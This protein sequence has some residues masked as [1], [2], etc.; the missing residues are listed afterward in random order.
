MQSNSP[1]GVSEQNRSVT[2]ARI[3]IL[4]AFAICLIAVM[5]LFAGYEVVE[6]TW[7]GA[8]EPAVLHTLHILRGLAAAAI[9]ATLATLVVLSQL[10]SETPDDIPESPRTWKNRLQRVPLRTKVIVPMV[11]LSAIPTF[12]IGGFTISRMEDSLR[13]RVVQRIEFDTYSKALSIQAFLQGLHRD[14]RFLSKMPEIQDLAAAE[15]AG[16]RERL[17]RFRREAER[18]LAIFSQGRRGYQQLRYLNSSAREVLRLDVASGTTPRLV[19]AKKLSDDA[20]AFY[21]NSAFSLKPGKI[22]VSQLEL[23]EPLGAS[24][25]RRKVL[26]CATPVTWDDGNGR[27]LLV[28]NV[29]AMYFF[30]LVGTLPRLAEAWLLNSEGMYLGYVGES[31]QKQAMYSMTMKRP[32]TADFDADMSDAILDTSGTRTLVH[33]NS[34]LSAAPI[35][36]DA[37]ATEQRWTLMISQPLA[38]VYTPVRQTTILLWTAVALVVAIAATTG[39]FVAHYVA[40]PIA[41]LRGAT[42]EIADGNLSKRVTV[43]TGDEIEGLATD[44]N[45][46]TDRLH[47]A[48]T[49]L[50]GWNDELQREVAK[51]TD[52]LRRL[53]SG[54]A[55]ADKLAS[56]GQMTA[57]IMHEIGNPLA[58]IKTKIQ[59]AQEAGENAPI[60]Q[61]LLP[62][63]IHEVNRLTLVLRSFARL[64]R[65]REPTLGLIS[66]DEVVTEVVTLV[67]AEL[68]RKR[69][70]MVIES[71]ND[72]PQI[73]ADADQLRQL[74]INFILNASDA[75]EEGGEIAVRVGIMPQDQA[76]DEIPHGASIQVVDH[77]TGIP[78][79]LLGKIWD[80]FFTTKPQGTGLGLPISRKIVEDHGGAV[81]I[82]SGPDGTV[83]TMIFPAATERYLRNGASNA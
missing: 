61:D 31:K 47:E 55:R 77:G 50:S 74:L 42:R 26:R 59:V 52:D 45:T 68:R 58:A 37:E 75:T 35:A 29:D 27:G 12:A 2:A 76:T 39:M 18:E 13:E 43:H 21:L 70:S 3:S 9:A 25:S 64:G 56:I 51:R 73:R 53:Q 38:P 11:L 32:I 69:I 65:L 6:R 34:L 16:D 17:P 10:E 40:R 72:A 22:Y 23:D 71:T 48:R 36:F 8:V 60:P 19:A 79:D 7:L 67:S 15:A 82:Q 62:A 33:E 63:L 66:P 81:T 49:R 44:F 14:L 83:V 46:M 20:D 28:V 24:N 5:I 54:L 57:S 1:R 4:P 78:A 30:S 41:L 80:P